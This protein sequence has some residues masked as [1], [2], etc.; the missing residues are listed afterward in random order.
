MNNMP[1]VGYIDPGTGAFLLQWI[2][3]GV[4]GSGV[5]FRQS[6]A[7]LL[8][9]VFRKKEGIRRRRILIAVIQVRRRRTKASSLGG[10]DGRLD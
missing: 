10:S 5:L 4:L 3:A 9:L 7:R 8:A 1:I 6:I 2:V